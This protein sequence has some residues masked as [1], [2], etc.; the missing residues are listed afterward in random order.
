MTDTGQARATDQLRHEHEVFLRALALLGGIGHRLEAGQPVDRDALAWLVEFFRTFVDRCHHAKEEQ[1]LFPALERR[2][3][4]RHGGPVAVMLHEH[5]QGRVFLRALTQQDDARVA[6]AIRGYAT[7]LRAHIDKEN[8]VLFP[9]ADQL[10]ADE[11][12]GRLVGA[13]EAVEQEV[14][15]PGIHERLLAELDRIEAPAGRPSAP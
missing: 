4:P 12:Q 9:M 8:Q 5:E 2:G 10:L 1:H 7:L 11:E 13:F 3:L 14:V 15:G 6:S